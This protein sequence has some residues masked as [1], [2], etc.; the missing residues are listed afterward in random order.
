MSD[1]ER[2]L[3][4]LAV[5][6]TMGGVGTV[7]YVGARYALARIR[8]IERDGEGARSLAAAETTGRLSQLEQDVA[9]LQDRLDFAERL[10]SRG[11][12]PER[13]D[14]GRELP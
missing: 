9:E 3:Q 14:A 8:R 10:L 13:L 6:T 5:L 2:L 4:L 1:F 7:F 11:A 12:E